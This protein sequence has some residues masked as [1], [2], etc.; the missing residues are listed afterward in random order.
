[1]SLINPQELWNEM[2]KDAFVKIRDE[3]VGTGN[4]VISA[5]SLGHDNVITGSD[6]LYTDGTAVPTASYTLNLDDGEITSFVVPTG[7]VLT[8]DYN[9]GDIDNTTIQSI[10]D[11]TDADIENKTGRTFAQATGTIEFIDVETGDT[12]FFLKEFPIITL[13]EV[14]IN[15]NAVTDAPEWKVL[16]EG[17]GNDYLANSQDL[18]D[19]RIRIIDNQPTEGPDRIRVTYNHGYATADIPEEIKELAI[20]KAQWRM[21]KSAIYKAIFKGF[22][23]F[24]PVKLAELKADIID[25]ENRL[26]RNR[27]DR[28]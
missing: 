9:Y 18:A 7:N 19:G 11:K 3:T 6:T 20:L 26:R 15:Q 14:A 23:N 21:S 22:D 4:G 27:Y 17:L 28:I 1:M 13:S 24:T 25:L 5:F 12:D 2:G 8:A 10:L 16:T